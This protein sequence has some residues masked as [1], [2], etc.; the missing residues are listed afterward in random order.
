MTWRPPQAKLNL[1]DMFEGL[2]NVSDDLAAAAE[3]GTFLSANRLELVRGLREGAIEETRTLIRG[4]LFDVPAAAGIVNYLMTENPDTAIN[5]I[6]QYD[7][8]L[9][10]S[11][12]GC[13]ENFVRLQ[14]SWAN[15]KHIRGQTSEVRGQ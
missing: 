3:I 7:F 11:L 5:A 13:R 4:F 6:E 2:K 1:R 9:A 12:R 15:V 8:A 14:T 10:E